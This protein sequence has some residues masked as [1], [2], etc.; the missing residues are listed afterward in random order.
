[1]KQY[2]E[3]ITELREIKKQGFVKT[4]RSGNTGIGK[5]LEDLL[6]IDENNIAGPNGHQTELKSARK[7]SS[8]MLT[9]F[10]K[11]PRPARINAKLL[12]KFGRT[13]DNGK[14]KLHT[15]LNA[16][17]KNT[18]YGKE[19]FRID[20]HDD[21]VEIAHSDYGTMPTPYWEKQE[22]E[23]AFN[24]KY[25]RNLLYVKADYRCSGKDEEFHFN[26]ACLMHGFDFDNFIRLLKKGDILVDIRIGQYPD[27][28]P[29][30][31]GT[32]FRVLQDKLDL[33]FT[34]RERVL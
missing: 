9:L 6:G 2:D 28:R 24:R 33:C 5:T 25:P 13:L 23:K 34:S 21:I 11:S 32:G 30:D 8:S 20:V 14:K 19:G 4:H 22:L 10:T 12:Q 3:L 27:G 7:G 15:T 1:M 31:H 29:H 18:L 17:S 16:V 26:E